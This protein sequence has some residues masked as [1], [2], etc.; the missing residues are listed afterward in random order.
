M[1]FEFDYFIHRRKDGKGSIYD[2]H[3]VADI[4]PPEKGRY[5][6]AP[7]DCYPGSSGSADILSVEYWD[8]NQFIRDDGFLT[9]QE[10]CKVAEHGI[11]L[12]LAECRD[13]F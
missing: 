8:G 13:S 10:T 2:L 9:P 11:E 12:W 6:G 1:Q 5:T 4:S 7:E 3:I